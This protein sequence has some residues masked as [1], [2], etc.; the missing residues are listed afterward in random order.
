MNSMTNFYFAHNF[1]KRHVYRKIELSLEKEYGISLFNPFY[2][3]LTREEEMNFMDSKEGR[4]GEPHHEWCIV[5]AEML[6]QRDLKNLANQNALL[7]IIEKPSIGTT[8]EIANAHMMKKPIYV[9]SELYYDHPWV[10]VYATH[11][12]KTISEFKEYIKNEV[13]KKSK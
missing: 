12:F 9:I 1:N 4:K 7:T 10:I 13:Y 5:N 6:V 3:D 2:D 11:I 8:L